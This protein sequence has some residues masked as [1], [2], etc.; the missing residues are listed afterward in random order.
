MQHVFLYRTVFNYLLKNTHLLDLTDEE[1]EFKQETHEFR[2]YLYHIKNF[3]Q[4][5]ALLKKFYQDRY[6]SIHP[7]EL[8]Y[9]N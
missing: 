4:R 3:P 9:A 2:T 6:Y 8:N 7:N 1:E 5:R